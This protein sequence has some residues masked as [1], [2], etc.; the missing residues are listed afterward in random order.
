M[1]LKGMLTD[2]CTTEHRMRRTERV[3][4]DWGTHAGSHVPVCDL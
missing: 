4:V 3:S 2:D 1:R